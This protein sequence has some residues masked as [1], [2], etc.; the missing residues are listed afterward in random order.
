MWQTMALQGVAWVKSYRNADYSSHVPQRTT[1]PRT[2]IPSLAC[3]A[4]L[5]SMTLPPPQHWVTSA[6]VVVCTTYDEKKIVSCFR[7]RADFRSHS[8][9]ISRLLD[10]FPAAAHP[11]PLSIF[12]SRETF[13]SYSSISMPDRSGPHHAKTSE[14]AEHRLFLT[15]RYRPSAEIAD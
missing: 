6:V 7:S 15:F 4:E 3:H 13:L 2:G 8:Q 1:L 5:A 10:C 12:F 14:A 11:P 9:E